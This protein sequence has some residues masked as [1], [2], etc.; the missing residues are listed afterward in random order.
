MNSDENA[1]KP[2]PRCPEP[3]PVSVGLEA[4]PGQDGPAE[5]EGEA[6]CDPSTQVPVSHLDSVGVVSALIPTKQPDV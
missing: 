6:A 3:C 5:W 2:Q 4:S 1:Q